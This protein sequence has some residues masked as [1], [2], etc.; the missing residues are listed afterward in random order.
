MKRLA[1]DF[2]RAWPDISRTRDILALVEE[3]SG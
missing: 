1:A 3:W 2:D